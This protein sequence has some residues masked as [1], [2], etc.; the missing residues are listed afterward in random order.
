MKKI[1]IDP[2]H[3]GSDNGA[4]W[5]GKFD[6]VEED[7]IN[8]IISFLLC[9]ELQLKGYQVELSRTKDVRVPLGE[10]VRM[11]NLCKADVFVSIHADAFHNTTAKGIS[12]HIHPEG[13]ESTRIF[14][15]HIQHSLTTIFYDHTNRGV[16]E[17]DFYVLRRT[18][19][20]AVL[21][22]AEFISNENTRRFLKEPE[23]Q[24]TMANGIA[25]GIN[26]YFFE[27]NA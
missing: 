18:I 10:R 15:G 4:T 11:A 9:Y 7:D 23:N 6:Y 21:I 17:N 26:N 27:K 25:L 14:A 1:F 3:G 24:R 16:K 22:E 5:G 12:V 8:L 13:T 19:M 20:P 2:G